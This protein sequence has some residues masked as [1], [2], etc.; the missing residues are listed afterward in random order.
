M[1]LGFA[2]RDLDDLRRTV[3]LAVE[4]IA[5]IRG[6]QLVKASGEVDAAFHAGV[7]AGARLA[8]HSLWTNTG[9]QFGEDLPPRKDTP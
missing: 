2:R 3:G 1:T 5:E 9:G 4:R 6:E 7:A 8:L